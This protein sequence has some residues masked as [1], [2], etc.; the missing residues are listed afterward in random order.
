MVKEAQE[1]WRTCIEVSCA[2]DLVQCPQDHAAALTRHDGL[3]RQ[4]EA[5]GLEGVWNLKP[6]LDGKALIAATGIAKVSCTIQ[7][8]R[9]EGG[10][11]VNYIED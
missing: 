3:V 11:S 1:L 7:Q 2:W 8:S 5:L 9:A 10:P 4:I 6:L